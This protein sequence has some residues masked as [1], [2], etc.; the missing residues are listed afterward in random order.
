M[1]KEYAERPTVRKE[2]WTQLLEALNS[3]SPL[4]QN[5][6]ASTDAWIGLALGMSGV[7]L[8]LVATREYVRAEIYIN[9]GEADKNKRAFDFLS[10]RK[11]EIE[12]A[13]GT[14]LDWARMDGQVTCRI[15]FEKRGLNIFKQAD[16]NEMIAFLVDAALRMHAA[17]REPVQELRRLR[18]Q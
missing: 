10:A 16:W 15:K 14:Q 5:V 2:F 8:N 4:A 1:K 12:K 11:E 3:K 9:R 6:G 17:F 13:V 18:A 7:S